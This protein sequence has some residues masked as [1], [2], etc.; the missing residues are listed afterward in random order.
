[1]DNTAIPVKTKNRKSLISLLAL[2]VVLILVGI[3]LYNRRTI[4]DWWTL[5]G[6]NPPSAVVQLASSDTMTGYARRVFYVNKPQIEDKSAFAPNCPSGTEQTVVLGCYHGGQSGIFLL[7]VTDSRLKGLEQVTAAHETLHAL[8]ERLGSGQRQQ[9]DGWLEDFY[10]TGLHDQTIKMQIDSYRKS[11]PHS[12]DDEMNSIIGT[13]VKQLPAPL[14]NYYR[15]Y[16]TD[17]GKVVAYYQNYQ[18]A[19]TERQRALKTDDAKLTSMKS[20]IDSLKS[21]L[22]ADG[23]KLMSERAQLDSEKAGGQTSDYN[24]RVPAFNA[25]VSSYNDKVAQLR[26][27]IASYNK[28]VGQ[29]N[30]VALEAQQLVQEI[31]SQPKK[32]Q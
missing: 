21:Q 23:Q 25:A 11:E 4:A 13:E 2:V 31:T 15:Q 9:V 28:L 20:Q 14:E 26:D 1:M 16:F 27:L 29:R 10:K 18:A 30:A 3:G 19:F 24:G 32:I 22:E 12:L 7:Q 6:Y 8:Y 5:L 17:R